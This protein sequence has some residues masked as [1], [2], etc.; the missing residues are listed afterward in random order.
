MVNNYK[1]YNI[2][3]TPT[4]LIIFC[5]DRVQGNTSGRKAVAPIFSRRADGEDFYYGGIAYPGHT[6][7]NGF[8]EID[9]AVSSEEIFR[10][11]SNGFRTHEYQYRSSTSQNYANYVIGFDNSYYLAIG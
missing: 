4:I 2:G 3:F 7:C 1:T 8:P 11:T 9:T 6:I 10:T 5:V